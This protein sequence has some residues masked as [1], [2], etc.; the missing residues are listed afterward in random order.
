MIGG[1]DMRGVCCDGD[2]I[3]FFFLFFFVFGV[4]VRARWCIQFRDN[5]MD[6]YTITFG[7]RNVTDVNV[8]SR[9]CGG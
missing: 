8:C 5:S 9:S 3:V 1:I 6:L 2:M 7:I 4:R